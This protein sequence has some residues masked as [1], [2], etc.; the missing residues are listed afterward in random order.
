MGKPLTFEV[1]RFALQKRAYATSA[2]LGFAELLGAP[3]VRIAK[4]LATIQ[5]S[6]WTS[7]IFFGRH[8]YHP[9]T[10]A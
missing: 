1:K 9:R 6:P 3:Q 8:G 5:Y 10:S 4:M 7:L 2:A